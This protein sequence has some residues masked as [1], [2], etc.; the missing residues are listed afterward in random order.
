MAGKASVAE[1]NY[2]ANQSNLM[3]DGAQ[4]QVRPI[5][6]PDTKLIRNWSYNTLKYGYRFDGCS[7]N[8][9]DNCTISHCVSFNDQSIMIKR[10]NHSVLNNIGFN[11]T[12][13]NGNG[14]D[15][16]PDPTI[17]MTFSN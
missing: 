1:M 6:Q 17:L 16:I 12:M 3:H 4:I 5:N 10:D 7:P 11:A 8:S 2:F 13:S 9:N 14:A 15:S